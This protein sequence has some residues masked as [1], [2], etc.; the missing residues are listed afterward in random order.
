LYLISYTKKEM[1]MG[2]NLIKQD[3][4]SLNNHPTPNHLTS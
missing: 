1:T 4:T 3:L 2:K